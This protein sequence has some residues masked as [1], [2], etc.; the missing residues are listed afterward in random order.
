MIMC[1][2][3]RAH[4]ARAR[5]RVFSAGIACAVA[6]VLG[7]APGTAAAVTHH[8]GSV[9]VMLQSQ[10]GKRQPFTFHDV[11]AS[12]VSCAHAK[13]FIK[14][15]TGPPPKGWTSKSVTLHSGKYREELI[16][17]HEGGKKITYRFS[18]SGS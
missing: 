4:G 17:R 5:I 3:R 1:S 18:A 7:T 11:T 14:R 8:C 10:N 6:T 13:S 12:G 16:W 15:L 2:G 9:T